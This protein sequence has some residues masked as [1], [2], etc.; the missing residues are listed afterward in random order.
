MRV[1]AA[2][3]SELVAHLANENYAQLGI[4]SY[5]DF[6]QARASA[7]TP[8]QR[9]IDA[10][11]DGSNSAKRLV[12]EAF[13]RE[14]KISHNKKITQYE[15]EKRSHDI[16]NTYSGDLAGYGAYVSSAYPQVLEFFGTR[17][18]FYLHESSRRLHTY[19]VGGSGS[20]KS[21]AIKSMIW[22]YL[23][24]ELDTAIVYVDPHNDIAEEVAKFRPNSTSDRL[25]YI[26]PAVSQDE[27]PGLNPFDVDGKELLSDQ[28]AEDYARAFLSAFREILGG[29]LTD[30]MENLLVNTIPV[31]VKMPGG[32][33]YD[34]IE[35]LTPR[36]KISKQI[37][38][39]EEQQAPPEYA[40]ERYVE[41]AKKN[42]RNQVMLHFLT[43]QFEEDTS[44][45]STRNSLTTRLQTVFGS[46]RM[47]A[48]FRG[49]RTI[50]LESL[51]PARKLVV[52][53]LA[54]L[55]EET[56]LIGRFVLISVKLFA[57]AQAA[58][59]LIKRTHCQVF[60]DECQKFVT[61]SISE[62]VQ[63]ARKFRIYLTLAQQSVG[64][65]MD[66][67]LLNAV[68][69]NAATK[70]TGANGG[71]SVTIMA[72]ET[73]VASDTI[74]NLRVGQFVVQQR[75]ASPQTAIVRM[76]TNTLRNRAGMSDDE[77]RALIASQM[78]KYYRAPSSVRCESTTGTTEAYE[79]SDETRSPHA[80]SSGKS[81]NDP[82]N[83]D[84]D[85]FL[86]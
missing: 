76:P 37:T 12:F 40:A 49:P 86:N 38:S 78:R 10:V 75:E 16:L 5:Q 65:E 29:N 30:Q 82:L 79:S 1:L 19:L 42:F 64:G 11:Y 67:K 28:Q 47:Q 9:P 6:V 43:R 72:K 34:L 71:D 8:P 50:K 22:H 25:V 48:L 74:K 80:P 2:E 85:I 4:P 77:W 17:R 24:E 59:P 23:H 46:T 35:F 39:T 44:Y 31:I 54:E 56:E 52:F 55:G 60:V 18:R 13:N 84:L 20:G 7:P 68:L 14:R 26:K 3:N 58:T 41:F 53:N 45:I 70:I 33:V 57:L 32:S 73:G 66:A 27:Y 81:S 21:E 51:I 15:K 61:D 69:T 62:I 63:E 83:A 36:Q